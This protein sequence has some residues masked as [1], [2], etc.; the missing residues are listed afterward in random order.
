MNCYK[1]HHEKC[2]SKVF[3]R[4]HTA[5]EGNQS[6]CQIVHDPK[7]IFND[8]ERMNRRVMEMAKEVNL[9]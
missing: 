9:N 5:C 2:N 4:H 6:K 7:S 3:G 1:W 8:L